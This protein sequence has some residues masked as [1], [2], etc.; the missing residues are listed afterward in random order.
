MIE[1]TSKAVKVTV[2]GTVQGVGLRYRVR[3]AAEDQ[4]LTGW[5]RNEADGTVTIHVEGVAHRIN[6]FLDW[7][8]GGVDG[9]KITRIET[10]P[11]FNKK[12]A[13]FEIIA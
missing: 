2:R 9:A 8:R 1:Q 6:N 13:E 4:N 7:L 12:Y 5:V 11:T 3:W 10:A